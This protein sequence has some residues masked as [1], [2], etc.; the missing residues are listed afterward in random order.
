[1]HRSI[2]KRV[3]LF[4]ERYA[5]FGAEDRLLAAVSGGTDSTALLSILAT[6]QRDGRVKDLLC[7][8]FN[9]RLRDQADRDEAFVK[10]LADAWAVPCLVE[11]R[12][13][14][15]QAQCDGCSVETAGRQWRL[16]RLQSLAR[17]H[18]CAAVVTGHHL[19]DNA[20]TLIHRLARG[21]G[22]RGLCG[23]RPVRRHGGV[24]L[25]SPLR[26]LTRQELAAYLASQKQPWCEDATNQDT[27]YTRNHIR[28]RLLPQLTRRCPSLGQS[29]SQ[30][31][32]ACHGLYADRV[33]PRVQTLLNAHVRFSIDCAVVTLP[34]LA[35]ESPLVLVELVRQTLTAM[36]TSL[37][38]VTQPHYRAVVALLRGRGRPVTLPG[39]MLADRKRGTVRF[40]RRPAGT[41]RKDDPL[42]LAL[43]GSTRLGPVELRTRIVDV[44]R[45]DKGQRD[46]RS[47][48]YFDL[49]KVTL[50]LHVRG[51]RPGDRFVPLG[52]RQAQKVGKFLSRADVGALD[53]S[54]VVIVADDGETILWVCPVRMS[55]AARV[56]P[57]TGK[58]L[59][60][61]ARIDREISDRSRTADECR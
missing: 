43:P 33:E 12:D 31:S 49:H 18:H 58:V 26:P 59:E 15:A 19:D 39:G 61:S 51:R 45:M 44:S 32:L 4:N 20:E 14:G 25:I 16:A 37:R 56:T 1:M 21:T 35:E 42:E 8:H 60:I 13:I 29:L 24:R 9:H 10:A 2:V 47:V 52:R 46:N 55:D 36:G 5:L 48:E 28:H 41:G 27:A 3:L 40:H 17:T 11:T 34:P 6:L 50:P 22:Y 38:T 57:R 23:I 30:L 7:V 53:P 54:D